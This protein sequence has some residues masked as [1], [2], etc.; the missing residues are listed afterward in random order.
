MKKWILTAVVVLLAVLIAAWAAL[1]KD[2]ALPD[3]S[4]PDNSLNQ[5]G[6]AP[7]RMGEEKPDD[8]DM[9]QSQGREEGG[10]GVYSGDLAYVFELADIEVTPSNCPTTGTGGAGVLLAEQQKLCGEELP[11]LDRLYEAYKDGDVVVLAVMWARKGRGHRVYP[12]ERVYFSGCCWIGCG[13]F[14][15]STLCPT[16]PPI[17]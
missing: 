1:Q 2:S 6:A 13:S 15:R 17:T 14:Q 16:C 10:Y 12:G 7:E 11:L 4:P 3:L 5:P 9:Q 8:S